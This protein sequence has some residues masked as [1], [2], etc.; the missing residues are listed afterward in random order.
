MNVQKALELVT[1]EHVEVSHNQFQTVRSWHFTFE[2]VEYRLCQWEGIKIFVE[3][4]RL[5][6]TK[7]DEIWLS[8]KA[9]QV[10]GHLNH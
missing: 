3:T 5:P 7:L 8:E 9:K 6:R 1:G 2:D 4:V 10:Y